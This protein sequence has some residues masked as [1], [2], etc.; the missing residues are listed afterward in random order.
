MNKTII[1]NAINNS[2]K[3]HTISLYQG[4]INKEQLLEASSASNSLIK[5]AKN[6]FKSNNKLD[7]NKL[8][9]LVE[10]YHG[11]I[12]KIVYLFFKSKNGALIVNEVILG[13]KELELTNAT[14]IKT[15]CQERH[16]DGYREFFSIQETHVNNSRVK[17]K[18]EQKVA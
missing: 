7:L 12:D 4:T 17:N 2:T 3:A 14:D 15:F 8:S 1:E 13:L 11:D 16:Y 10:Y 5:E 9:N 18:K 6:Y